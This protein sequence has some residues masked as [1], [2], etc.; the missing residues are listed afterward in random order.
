MVGVHKFCT[1][2]RQRHVR[3]HVYAFL[4]TE[5]TKSSLVKELEE[6]SA[7]A[8]R[9]ESL[10]KCVQETQLELENTQHRLESTMKDLS[11]EQAKSRSIYKHDQVGI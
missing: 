6:K 9:V 7:V 3:V 5:R 10:E 8:S 1:T 11:K 2:Q 4:L